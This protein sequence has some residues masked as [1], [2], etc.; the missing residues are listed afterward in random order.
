VRDDELYLA[1]AEESLAGAM[2]ELAFGR[3]NNCMNRS[4]YACLQAAIAALVRA[5]IRP[6][7]KRDEWPH[8]FVHGRFADQLIRRRHLFPS[9][10]RTVLPDLQGLRN[11]A[12]Y[13][14][15]PVTETEARRI[16]RRASAFVNAIRQVGGSTP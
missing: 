8:P 10:L 14:L 1:K 11:R 12:D 15:E 16:V 3:Y 6:S 4:Y 9:E 5:G 13:S 2:S 7:G